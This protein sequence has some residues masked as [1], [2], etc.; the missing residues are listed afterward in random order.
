MLWA[1][2]EMCIERW[3]FSLYLICNT[4]VLHAQIYHRSFFDLIVG[5]LLVAKDQQPY[6]VD[7]FGRYPEIHSYKM[8]TKHNETFEEEE[9]EIRKDEAASDAWKFDL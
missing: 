1:K 8:H 2:T 4:I 9:S 6:R 7:G 5:F 3:F